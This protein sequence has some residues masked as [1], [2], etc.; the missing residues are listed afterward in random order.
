MASETLKTHARILGLLTRDPD[1]FV[2][3]QRSL[4]LK[5]TGLTEDEVEHY[6]EMRDLARQSKN[7]AEADRIRTELEQKRIQ[8]EDTPQGTRW[9]VGV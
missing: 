2:E 6:I 9:R 5:T 7:F 8:L 1:V 3:E 4:K